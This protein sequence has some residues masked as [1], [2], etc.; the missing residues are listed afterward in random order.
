[1]WKKYLLAGIAVFICF[2]A[3]KLVSLFEV[4]LYGHNLVRVELIPSVLHWTI[5]GTIWLFCTYFIYQYLVRKI[6]YDVLQLKKTPSDLQFAFAM[7]IVLIIVFINFMLLGQKLQS[8]QEFFDLYNIFGLKCIPTMVVEYFFYACET[9]LVVMMV[10]LGQKV[11]ELISSYKGFPW[12]GLF[13]A[14]T[15]GV[16]RLLIHGNAF[17]VVCFI[18]SFLYGVIYLLMR[19]NIRYSYLLIFCMFVI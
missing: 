13:L 2:G 9:T 1:M 4:F 14:I 17:G 18:A 12:G 8:V 6:D 3:E 15:W 19:K 7:T 10:I 5:T 16:T 11:G